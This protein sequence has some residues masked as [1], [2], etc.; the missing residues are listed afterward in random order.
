ME[1]DSYHL[2]QPVWK[3]II[4]DFWTD[5]Y[6]TFDEKQKDRETHI[7]IWNAIWADDSIMVLKH[8]V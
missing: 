3:A 1:V 5:S 7:C 8:F 4:I 2:G 6:Q